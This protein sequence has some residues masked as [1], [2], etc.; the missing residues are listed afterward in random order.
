MVY[1]TQMSFVECVKLFL[2]A[3]GRHFDSLKSTL[4]K[5]TLSDSAAAAAADIDAI[6]TDSC[7]TPPQPPCQRDFVLTHNTSVI[8][9]N[10]YCT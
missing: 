3:D 6:Q 2:A 7:V 9:H 5:Q 1:M 8:V 10:H 4:S